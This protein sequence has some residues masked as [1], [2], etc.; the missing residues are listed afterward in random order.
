MTSVPQHDRYH[1]PL[2]TNSNAAVDDYV[3]GIDLVLSGNVGAEERLATAIRSDEGFALA[4]AALASVDLRCRRFDSARDHVEAARTLAVGTR[5][6][7]RWQ[8]ERVVASNS[9]SR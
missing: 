9:M 8:S 7:E 2:S 3:Q 5:R 1:L 6:R 4:H